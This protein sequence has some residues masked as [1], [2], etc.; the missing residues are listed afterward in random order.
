M[1]S[2]RRLR[3]VLSKRCPVCLRGAMFG[4]LLTMNELCASCGHRFMREEGF[5]QGAM[6]VSYVLGMLEFAGL[7]MISWAVLA[8]RIGLAGALGIAFVAHLLLVPQLFQYSRVLWAH[9]N[10]GTG[11]EKGDTAAGR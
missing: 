11:A 6:Y 3:A 7:A 1:I 9:L 4:G 8:P 5:F 10:V 2:L